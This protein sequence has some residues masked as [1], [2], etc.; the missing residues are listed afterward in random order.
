MTA[1]DHG[2][3]RGT[4]QDHVSPIWVYAMSDE[5]GRYLSAVREF[6]DAKG[7]GEIV[8]DFNIEPGVKLTGTVLE[9]GTGRPIV[10][11]PRGDCHVQGHVVAG[12]VEY[13]PL[14]TNVALRDTP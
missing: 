2:R 9:A 3:F 6:N 1:D 4:G 5:P 12:R 11:S 14:A 13:F 10:S 7:P 8:A